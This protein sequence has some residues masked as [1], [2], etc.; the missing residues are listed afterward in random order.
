MGGAVDAAADAHGAA[1]GAAASPPQQQQL[2][3]WPCRAASAEACELPPLSR[4]QYAR[5]YVAVA[6]GILLEW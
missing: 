2:E 1:R 6:L 5:M 3:Q 4:G